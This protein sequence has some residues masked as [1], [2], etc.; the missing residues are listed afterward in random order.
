VQGRGGEIADVEGN[1]HRGTGGDSSGEDMPVLRMV[2]DAGEEWGVVSLRHRRLRELGAQRGD[3][4]CN[5]LRRTAA[6]RHEIA[7]ELSQRL[8][9]PC[10][11][12]EL[13]LSQIEQRV[14]QARREEDVRVEGGGGQGEAE[15]RTGAGVS[16]RRG[17]GLR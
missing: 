7:R 8:R 11:L 10:R 16:H 3:E 9:A 13:G 17:R 4:R 6:T 1:D 12:V 14:P 5:P 2:G 15:R